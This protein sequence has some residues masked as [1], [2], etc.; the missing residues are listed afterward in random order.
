VIGCCRSCKSIDM[1]ASSFSPL[2]QISLLLQ[3]LISGLR[4]T[5]TAS[6]MAAPIMRR[7]TCQHVSGIFC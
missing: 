1:V 3:C 4:R 5:V 2:K 6:A 7:H